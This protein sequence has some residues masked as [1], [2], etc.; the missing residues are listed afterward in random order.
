VSS[1]DTFALHNTTPL[2]LTGMV[3]MLPF[4]M[5]ICSPNQSTKLDHSRNHLVD[6]VPRN[7]SPDRWYLISTPHIVSIHHCSNTGSGRLLRHQHSSVYP[8][9]CPGSHHY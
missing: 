9:R 4:L 8:Q 3:H 1:S 6:Q 2:D 5:R 7:H